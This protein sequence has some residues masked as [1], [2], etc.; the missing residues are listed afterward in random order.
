MGGRDTEVT[1]ATTDILI[2]SAHFDPVTVR[3][4]ARRLDMH[5]DASHRFER[6]ADPAAPP[7]AATRVAKLVADL[8]GGEMLE[9]VADARSETPPPTLYGTLDHERLEAFGGVEIEP[10]TVERILGGLGFDLGSEGPAIW[11][12]GVPSWRY[13]DMKFVQPDG[14]VYEAD[15]F[16]EV[17]RHVGFDNV[18]S[19]LPPV[20]EPDSGSSA[21]HFQ[22]QRQRLYL[23][24]CGLAEAIN[25]AFGSEADDGRFGLWSE[26]EPVRLTNPLSELYVV[27]RR[28]LMSGLLANA[29]FNQRRGA[30]AVRLFEI[31]HLFLAGGREVETVAAVLGGTRGTPWERPATFDVFDLKGCVEGLAARCGAAVAA[32][33]AALPGVVRGTGATLHAADADPPCGWIGQ[34]DARDAAYPLFGAELETAAL[35]GGD[36]YATVTAPSRFPAVAVDLTLTHDRS[37]AW[38]EI[39]SSIATGVWHP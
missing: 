32:R 10:H 1:D 24:A 35:A 28:S 21:A 17:L 5:T 27:M 19:A 31:G 2:E 3:R 39:E 6:G 38:R 9:G 8:A 4:G 34:L 16:E 14:G 7:L 18:P 12:V 25:Y 13:H 11:R 20:E 33:P 15:L 29:E 36:R 23:S 30:E 37:L 26:G 22:R